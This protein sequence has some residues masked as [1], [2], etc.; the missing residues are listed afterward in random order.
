MNL[1][2]LPPG[3]NPPQVVYAVIEIPRGG[4]NKYEYDPQLGLFRLDRVLYSAVHYPAA[5][6][7]IPGTRA[8]DGDPVD[9]LVMVS[10]PTFTGCLLEAR[11]VGLFRMRDEKGEDEKILAVPLADPHYNEVQNLSDVPPHFLHE[12][13]HFFRIYKDLEGK[14]VETF[15]WDRREAAHNIIRTAI[16]AAQK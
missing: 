15:G 13:E 8:E 11:P 10:E 14:R 4:R 1:T 9:I 16:A 6:G 2:L 5:Y 12:V 3:P 7:F